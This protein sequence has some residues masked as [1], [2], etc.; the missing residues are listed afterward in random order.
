[1]PLVGSC[2]TYYC[3]R[4][5]YLLT[6]SMT[7]AVQLALIAMVVP[8]I[9]AAGTLYVSVKNSKKSDEIHTMVNGNNT[10]MLRE[11]SDLK[12]RVAGLTG[13]SADATS[14]ESAKLSLDEK[15]AV[16][17]GLSK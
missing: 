3:C 17:A 15:V 13:R 4:L 10:A 1:M 14:A 7:E 11:I 8:T 6:S 9:V 12:T 5:T 2:L 16:N